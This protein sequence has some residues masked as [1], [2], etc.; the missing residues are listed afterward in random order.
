[1]YNLIAL[2]NSRNY[3]S[4]GNLLYSNKN[5]KK[6]HIGKIKLNLKW[7]IHPNV[8]CNIIYNRQ[9]ME[10]NYLSIDLLMDKEDV[11]HTYNGM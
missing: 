8:H 5:F 4:I 11:V 1:M 6:I 3:H 7:Y 10:G 2:L 9:D